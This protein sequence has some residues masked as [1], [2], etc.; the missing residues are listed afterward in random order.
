MPVDPNTFVADYL[1]SKFNYPNIFITEGCCKRC[2]RGT[3]V[4]YNLEDT[5]FRELF[6]SGK[7]EPHQAASSFSCSKFH[8]AG[9]TKEVINVNSAPKPCKYPR[10]CELTCIVCRTFIEGEEGVELPDVWPGFTAHKKCLSPCTTPCCRNLLPV[11]PVFMVPQRFDLKCERHRVEAPKAV[12]AVQPPKPVLKPMEA[13]KEQPKEQ[14]KVM[15][16]KP[17]APT[18]LPQ[19]LP[20]PRIVPPEPPVKRTFTFKKSPKAKADKF[21]ERGKSKS[22]LNFLQAPNIPNSFNSPTNPTNPNNPT[23]HRAEE[24]KRLVIQSAQEDPPR[25]FIRNKQTGEIF[26]E[27]RGNCAYKVGTDTILFTREPEPTN[28]K[29]DFTPPKTL[30][31][32]AEKQQDEGEA[33]T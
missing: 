31:S 14:P 28:Y 32:S 20:E 11:L 21:D 22:I 30:T 10:N 25:R 1:E 24:V 13:P 26:G 19:P 29:F 3:K 2:L 18:K 15:L 23:N 7:M 5:S 16:F 6:E 9:F 17:P 33:C 8:A 27:W 4:E 12:K